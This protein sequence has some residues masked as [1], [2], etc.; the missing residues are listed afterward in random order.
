MRSR[1]A[2]RDGVAV[3]EYL[4]NPGRLFVVVDELRRLSRLRPPP[5]ATRSW[6]GTG[7][8]TADRA[9]LESTPDLPGSPA[10]VL[11]SGPSEGTPLPLEG[12][13]PWAVG[14]AEACDVVVPHDPYVSA[15]NCR[16]RRDPEGWSVRDHAE[17]TNGTTLNWRLLP[18]GGEVPI[19][20]GDTIGLGRT[21]MIFRLP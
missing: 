15:E 12:P 18:K 11:A 13:G 20:S 16:L 14:R 10:L 9:G 8:E 17:S 19:R 3:R 6:A 4:V 2:S 5:S 1:A 7:E 21:I